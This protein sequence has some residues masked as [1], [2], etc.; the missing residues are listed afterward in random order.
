MG[1]AKTACSWCAARRNPKTTINVKTHE[2]GGGSRA[3]GYDI[4]MANGV[5]G[6]QGA[7]PVRDEYDRLAGRSTEMKR[8][9]MVGIAVLALGMLAG[10]GNDESSDTQALLTSVRGLMTGWATENPAY[11]QQYISEDYAFDEQN[12]A[13]HIASIVADFPDIRNFRL[14]NQRLDIV[15]SNIASVQVEF[16]ASLFA[17]IASLDEPTAILAWVPSDNTLDQVWI[18]DFDGVWRLAAE[19]LQGSWVRDDTPVIDFFS[20]APGDRI[21]PGA[22]GGFSATGSASSISYRVTLWPDSIAAA[23]FTP[24]FAFGFGVADYSGDITV[25][26]DAF[27]EYSFSMIGQTDIIG[28]PRMV[29]RL[30]RAVYIVVSDRSTGRAIIG[31]KTVPGNKQSIFRLM[32]IRRSVGQLKEP[33]PGAGQ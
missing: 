19:Y 14:I 31:G 28:N 29:G 21:A 24:Q 33:R 16:T 1:V 4:G 26:T 2:A 12:K 13:D 22:T 8:W 10:C 18:K 5:A 27:G 17:D 9:L 15:T 11:L 25:R 23:Y 7:A 30:L 32:R 20:V 6:D 3:R